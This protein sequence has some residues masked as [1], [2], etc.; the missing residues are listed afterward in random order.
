MF[1]GC[2]CKQNKRQTKMVVVNNENIIEPEIM[3]L[4]SLIG[5]EQPPYTRQELNRA[6]EY[7]NGITN[8]YEEKIYLYDFHNKYHREQL[9]PSC[10]ICLPRIQSRINDM[11]KIL[12]NYDQKNG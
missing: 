5:D 10:A 9:Q 2:G 7:L 1:F 8:S 12:D 11:K 6:I 4:E 3:T